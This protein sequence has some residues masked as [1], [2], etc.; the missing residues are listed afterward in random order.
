M[1][2]GNRTFLCAEALAGL[3]IVTHCHILSTRHLTPHETIDGHGSTMEGESES[4]GLNS[5]TSN[6]ILHWDYSTHQQD[7]LTLY[8]TKFD[9]TIELSHRMRTVRKFKNAG[10]ESQVRFK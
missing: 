4:A 1:R 9:H 5:C 3:L 7:I 8:L 10:W 6:V 2:G